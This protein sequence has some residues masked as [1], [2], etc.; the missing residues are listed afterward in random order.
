MLAAKHDPNHNLGPFLHQAGFTLGLAAGEKLKDATALAGR[1]KVA[2]HLEVLWVVGAPPSHKRRRKRMEI[3][4]GLRVGVMEG[5]VS[6]GWQQAREA[7]MFTLKKGRRSQSD[8]SGDQRRIGRKGAL[9]LRAMVPPGGGVVLVDDVVT[10]GATMREMSDMIHP[11]ALL[12]VSLSA[13]V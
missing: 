5:L 4:P 1:L 2:S 9:S 3:V 11:A 12:A 10:T 7:D 6:A 8:L 13:A